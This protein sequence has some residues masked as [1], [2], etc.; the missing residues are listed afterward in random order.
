MQ[1]T[2]SEIARNIEGL[3]DTPANDLSDIHVDRIEVTGKDTWRQS[4]EQLRH[5]HRTEQLMVIK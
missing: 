5:T 4:V 2:D 1:F 3:L